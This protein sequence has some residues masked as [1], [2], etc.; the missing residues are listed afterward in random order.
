[1]KFLIVMFAFG[2]VLLTLLDSIH[3]HTHTL[4]YVHPFAF[5]SAW[6]VPLLMGSSSALGGVFYVTM[7][8][9][10]GGST[11]LPKR[12]AVARA[13][14]AFAV[15]YAAS[16]LLPASH[17]TKL[18]V[19]A[20]GAVVIYREVDRTRAGLILLVIGSIGGTIAEAINHGFFYL[21]PDFFRVP[22]WL[23][24]LYACATPAMGQFARVIA[25]RFPLRSVS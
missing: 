19:L 1:M 13:L 5:E 25:A 20:V 23:P 11:I 6:W 8:S 21:E 7:W 16:G 4:A 22:F 12:S 9:R 24:A 14:L 17:T 3:V 18:V 2:A 10:L 15:M